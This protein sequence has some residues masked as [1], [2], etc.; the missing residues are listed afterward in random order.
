MGLMDGDGSN[1]S[2]HNT[3]KHAE[4]LLTITTA[5]FHWLILTRK[6]WFY[7]HLIIGCD[8]W[9]NAEVVEQLAETPE[10]SW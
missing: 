4:H 9:S 2:S 5:M 3:H 6:N 1:F 7:L 8:Q 10:Q